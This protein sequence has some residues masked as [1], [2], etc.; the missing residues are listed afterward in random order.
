MPAMKSADDN[1]FAAPLPEPVEDLTMVHCRLF[2]DRV[3]DTLCLLRKREL[4][5]RG[6]FSCGECAGNA[7]H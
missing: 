2:N 5:D 3:T 6:E 4:D 7:V 1:V